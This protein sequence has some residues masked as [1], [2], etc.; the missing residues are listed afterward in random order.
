M[1]NSTDSVSSLIDRFLEENDFS[2]HT[3]RA[4]RHDLTTFVGWFESTNKEGFEIGRVT[5]SDISGFKDQSARVKA[6]R[7]APSTEPL[8]PCGGSMR[9]W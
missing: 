1:K 2:T 5:A 3:S 4:F 8:S 9:G 7:S 6:R